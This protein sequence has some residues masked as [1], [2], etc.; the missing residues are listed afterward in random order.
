MPDFSRAAGIYKKDPEDL[1]KDLKKTAKTSQ[2]KK[3]SSAKA[4]TP[5]QAETSSEAVSEPVQAVIE[6]VGPR[7]EPEKEFVP[8]TPSK[9]KQK[10]NRQV[11]FMVTPEL[12]ERLKITAWKKRKTVN[13]FL[14][15]LVDANTLSADDAESLK[16]MMER[17]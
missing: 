10:R 3:K 1:K 14:F 9:P 12:Y 11:G 17:I 15:D 8:E 7:T 2:N 16:E 6:E 13:G 4:S 5:P